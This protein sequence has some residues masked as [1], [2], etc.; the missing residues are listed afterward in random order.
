M[1]FTIQ[2]GLFRTIVAVAASRIIDNGIL[3]LST[4][5]QIG[6]SIALRIRLHAHGRRAVCFVGARVIDACTSSD[7]RV[8]KRTDTSQST[9]GNLTRRRVANQRIRQNERVRDQTIDTAALLVGVT[10]VGRALVSVV[11]ILGYRVASSR[12]SVTEPRRAIVV[13]VAKTATNLK[14]GVHAF[15]VNTCVRR[16][17][18]VVVADC[19]QVRTRLGSGNTTAR[20]RVARRNQTL[21]VRCTRLVRVNALVVQASINRAVLVVVADESQVG[22]RLADRAAANIVVTKRRVANVVLGTGQRSRG[23]HAR[24]TVG[25]AAR[26]RLAKARLGLA[27]GLGHARFVI[28]KPVEFQVVGQGS[29]TSRQV[30]A[31]KTGTVRVAHWGTAVGHVGARIVD[32]ST[33]G[34]R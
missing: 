19:S 16:T 8:L 22:V 31:T 28:T 13:A 34:R 11:A 5:T 3:A 14:R 9:C 7:R 27:R 12:C 30:V 29:L 32:T 33:I 4:K 23:F 18:I 20:G 17:S 24:S 25:V 15:T 26:K 2:L 1:T 21:V 6:D 10:A